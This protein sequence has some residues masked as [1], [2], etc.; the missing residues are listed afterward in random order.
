MTAYPGQTRTALGQLCATL[1]EG[2]EPGTVVTASYTEMQ[3]LRPLRHSGV[4]ECRRCA[5][6]V[7][8]CVA[9]CFFIEC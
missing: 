4:L 3:C 6:L 5:S 2:I 8:S 9:F 1:W 7:N